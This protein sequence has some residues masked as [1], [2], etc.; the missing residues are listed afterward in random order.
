M[1]W[2]TYGALPL[3][4][5]MSSSDASLEAVRLLVRAYPAGV[6]KWCSMSG[7][8]IHH[9]AKFRNSVDIVELLLE[10]MGGA[11]QYAAFVFDSEK[12]LPFDHA[13]AL[14]EVQRENLEGLEEVVDDRT[15]ILLACQRLPSRTAL[16]HH[17]GPLQD[18]ESQDLEPMARY[19]VAAHLPERNGW[20][21]DSLCWDELQPCPGLLPLAGHIWQAASDVALSE[22]LPRLVKCLVHSERATLHAVLRGLHR[23][24]RRAH[25]R[26]RDARVVPALPLDP[27]FHILALAFPMFDSEAEARRHAPYLA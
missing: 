21:W 6:F 20:R 26:S 8:P 15:L 25:S 13:L 7:Y 10:A 14:S 17:L 24:W 22:H 27:L 5:V 4:D 2:D 3:H 16:L 12:K 19:V 11:P 1:V 23:C 9:A 18:V